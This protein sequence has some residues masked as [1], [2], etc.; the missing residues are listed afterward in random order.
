MQLRTDARHARGSS[1]RRRLAELIV[2]IGVATFGV[3]LIMD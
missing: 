2:A 3:F 1:R